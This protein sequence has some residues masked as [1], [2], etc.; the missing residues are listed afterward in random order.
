VTVG[1]HRSE[2]VAEEIRNE[3]GLML[4]GDLRDP[5]LSG[6]LNVTEVRLTPDMRTA[7]VYVQLEGEPADREATMEG[8]K[9]AAGFVRHELVERLQLRRAP[10]ILFVPDESAEYGQRIDTLLKDVRQPKDK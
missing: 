4:A 8:L 1:G 10:E 3:I 5:R 2:R 7:R 6:G 9:A